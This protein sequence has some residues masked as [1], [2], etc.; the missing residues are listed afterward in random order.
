[1][2]KRYRVGVKNKLTTPIKSDYYDD[3]IFLPYLTVYEE[4]EAIFDT[5]ILDEY[6]QPIH[7]TIEREPIGYIK[8]GEE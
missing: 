5:G 2:R 4:E 8:R 1:M 7:Y 6:G 3:M